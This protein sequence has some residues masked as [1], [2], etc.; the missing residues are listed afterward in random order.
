MAFKLLNVDKF[1]QGV[2][3]KTVTN[4]YTFNRNME[5]TDTGLQSVS[6]FGVSSTERFNT[7]GTIELKDV[8]MHP[9][10]YENLSSIDPVFKR[11]RDK[12][13]KYE[14]VSGMLKE[15]PGGDTGVG[16]LIANW[17]KINFD[18]YRNEKNKLFI[19]LVK[20]SQELLF[21]NK[22]PVI[23][24]NYREANEGSFKMEED[25]VD[26]LYKSILSTTKDGRSDFTSSMMEK[27]K[28]K[29]GKDFIQETVNKLYKHFISKL[30]SKRGFLRNTLTAKRLDN[31]TRLVA[32]ARPD[33]PIDSCV[34]PWQVLL[35]LFDTFIIGALNIDDEAEGDLKARLGVSNKSV[36]EMGELF[37]FIYRNVDIYDKKYPEKKQ[38]WIEILVGIFNENP[39]LRVL[40]K[41]DPGWNADSLWCFQP[42]I[43]S[44]NRYN[45]WVPSWVYSPLGGDSFNTNFITDYLK[46]D[47]IF[48]DDDYIITGDL[49]RARAIKTLDSIWKRLEKYKTEE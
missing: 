48:E 46:D 38:I 5:P 30:E 43:N 1:L 26:V 33:V 3:A 41:R 24:V 7:W 29:T 17:S 14:I 28:D 16:W 15:S 9:L 20:N 44:D 34:L 27:I 37:D 31:V 32:N 21:I 12:S 40:I 45:I 18:K 23:P 2:K 10:I 19:D 49:K 35:G 25:E 4:V 36:D 8:V 47:I 39:L 11:A 6:I 13:K 42:L 22:I